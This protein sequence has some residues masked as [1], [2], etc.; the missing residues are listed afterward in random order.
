MS[1]LL[2]VR[3]GLTAMTGPMLA[4][5]TPGIHLDDRGLAQARAAA[6]RVAVLPVAGV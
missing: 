4:G 5:R 2:L 1:T 3:H 6:A